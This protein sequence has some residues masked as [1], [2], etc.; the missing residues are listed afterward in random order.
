MKKRILSLALVLMLCLGMSVPALAAD[1]AMVG[2]VNTISLGS[3]DI[4]AVVD[5]KGV[6]W[7]SAPNYQNL[8][9]E[10]RGTSPMFTKIMENVRTVSCGLW[11][12]AVVKTDGSLWTFTTQGYYDKN[13]N[14]IERFTSKKIMDGVVSVS[15][16]DDTYA[17]IKE[18]GSLWMW[19]KNSDGQLGNGTTNDSDIP[20]RVLENVVA[21]SCDR[22]NTAAITKDGSLWMWG[23][24]SGLCNEYYGKNVGGSELQTVPIKIMENVRSV[25]CGGFVT[26]VVKTDSSL[27]VW[28]FNAS[29]QMANGTAGWD[30]YKTPCKVMDNVV[31]VSNNSDVSAAVKADGS[32]WM[33][34]QNDCGNVGNG[35]SGTVYSTQGIPYQLTPCKVLDNVAVVA[36]GGF[37][38]AA[39]KT[40]GSVWFWGR[41]S[42]L[43]GIGN[44]KDPYDFA[45]QTTPVQLKGITAKISSSAST[46]KP[47]PT[48]TPG[49]TAE[50]VGG[51]NDVVK[52]DY[53]ADSVLWA[54][55]KGITAGTSK[56]TFSPNSTCT[57]AQ[58]LTFLW[59]SQGS[60]EP[61]SK[62]NTFTDIKE[63]DY[64]YK[65][66]LWAKENNIV[67]RDS[68]VFNG[69]TP[70]TRSMAVLYIWRA[71][72][73]YAAEKH[74]N[75]TDV[76]TTTIYAPAVDWA[77]EQGVTSGTSKTTFSP[78]T[79]CTRAQIVT[80]LYRAFSK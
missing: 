68:T 35:Y 40:D 43:N 32:L 62:T 4:L 31:S 58:I 36:C 77:V 11:E 12:H 44:D 7:V 48:P 9:L 75:F 41:S 60:P 47:T 74:S 33:W 8:G 10:N 39:V 25:N 70:C 2:Q 61:T 80:F 72:G 5:T 45:M 50:K 76:A 69:N 38:T 79:T 16:S 78:D 59:R 17:A 34:G 56:T 23:D 29:G 53:F 1:S 20:V 21:V 42:Y 57:T 14:Y 24:K 55:D 63:S 19:G 37:S 52:T 6:L 46:S 64:F 22:H 65:A 51:F 26:T 49:I 28:G 66:A 27:W 67:S 13:D 3:S 54:V 71:A 18:D 15:V 73:F 30:T